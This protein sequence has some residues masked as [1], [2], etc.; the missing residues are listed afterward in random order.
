MSFAEKIKEIYKK[1]SVT[2]NLFF[3]D[4]KQAF[5]GNFKQLEIFLTSG[6]LC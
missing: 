2:Y 1:D 4:V 6:S 3:M 5:A